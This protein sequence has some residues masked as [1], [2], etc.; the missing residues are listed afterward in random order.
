MS[1]KNDLQRKQ[2][3]RIAKTLLE[4][5]AADVGNKPGEWSATHFAVASLRD[6]NVRRALSDL[7]EC[8]GFFSNE[9]GSLYMIFVKAIRDIHDVVITNAKGE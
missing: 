4:E 3:R 8:L 6:G 9:K 7:G 2:L 1:K 5:Y